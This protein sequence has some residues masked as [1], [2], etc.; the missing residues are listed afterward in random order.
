MLHVFEEVDFWTRDFLDLFKYIWNKTTSYMRLHDLVICLN[1]LISNSIYTETDIYNKLIAYL[2]PL[3][4]SKL[5]SYNHINQFKTR[6]AWTKT[7]LN[8]LI[9]MFELNSPCTQL[10]L[11]LRRRTL[12]I[13]CFNLYTKNEKNQ[14]QTYQ[15]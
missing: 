6:N 8:L 9:I 15:M 14:K 13:E 2:T 7:Y 12:L 1:P 5:Y 3:I 4:N 10:V 11:L